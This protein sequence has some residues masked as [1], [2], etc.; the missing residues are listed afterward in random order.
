MSMSNFDEKPM[1]LITFEN[2]KI[3]V[4]PEAIE[5]LKR[6]PKPISV[7]GV[8]G[9]YR[10]GKSFL[11]NKVILNAKRG[12]AVGETIDPCT[13]G[14]WIWGRPLKG[15]TKDGKIVNIIVLDSE[16]LAAIDVDSNHDSRVFSLIMLLS[17]VFLYNSMGAIDEG[18][19]E[20]LSL[21]INLTKN[22]QVKVNNED[23]DYEDYAHFMPNFLWVL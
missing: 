13:K 21:I 7:L 19:L 11:L 23:A 4:N 15:T 22:I 1:P 10:T 9:N 12:F 8:A 3:V 18:A 5:F 6:V 2:Q 20:N 17:S 16:G 14:I